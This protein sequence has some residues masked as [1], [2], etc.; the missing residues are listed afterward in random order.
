LTRFNRTN[1]GKSPFSCIHTVEFSIEARGCGRQ[2]VA[3]KIFCLQKSTPKMG[4]LGKIKTTCKT[5]ELQFEVIQTLSQKSRNLF[6][7]KKY[8]GQTGPKLMALFFKI[9]FSNIYFTGIKKS[10]SM[11]LFALLSYIKSIHIVIC[12]TMLDDAQEIA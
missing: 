6:I 12:I 11:L 1:K 7:E 5:K 4:T 2:N 10:F 9:F 8:S 3:G